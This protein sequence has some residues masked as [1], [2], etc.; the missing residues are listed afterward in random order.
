MQFSGVPTSAPA[1]DASQ[2]TKG[3]WGIQN[4]PMPRAMRG[5]S[6]SSSVATPSIIA[7]KGS[8]P[9]WFA[10]SSTRPGGTRSMPK[11]CARKYQR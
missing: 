1:R 11:V 9:A 2:L 8:C 3:S 7:S 10:I 4:S 5:G 6:P